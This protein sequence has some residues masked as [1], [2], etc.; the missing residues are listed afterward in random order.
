MN[1]SIPSQAHP[2]P[3]IQLRLGQLVATPAALKAM[4]R[5]GTD[6]SLLLQRHRTGDWGDL[7]AEDRSAN[8]R[9][10]VAGGRILSA[11]QLNDDLKIWIITEADRS[12][13]CILLPEEY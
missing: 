2:R 6:P 5:A 9:A 4:T 8:D 13:T 11:Y 1:E 12:S 7:D 3:P 10:V